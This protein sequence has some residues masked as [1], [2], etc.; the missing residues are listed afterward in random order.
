M[1]HIEAKIL[2]QAEYDAITAITATAVP[3]T[4]TLTAGA[5]LTGGGDLS[6]NRTFDVVAHVDGSVVVNAN[7]VQVGVLATDA[8]HGSLSLIHI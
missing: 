3:N 6:A 5:G 8:Q 7:D 1:S 2:S 4:R